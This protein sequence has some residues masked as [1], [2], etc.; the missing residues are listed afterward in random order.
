[1]VEEE[2]HFQQAI[3]LGV[4]LDDGE[5]AALLGERNNQ[6][7]DM[8]TYHEHL[9]VGSDQ[10]EQAAQFLGGVA[11]LRR[12]FSADHHVLDPNQQGAMITLHQQSRGFPPDDLSSQ[13][14]ELVEYEKLEWNQ[15]SHDRAGKTPGTFY[16]PLAV[17]L[18]RVADCMIPFATAMR[19]FEFA[20]RTDW[21]LTSNAYTRALEEHR[22][23]GKE[24]LD[25]T[26]SN[27]TN[28]G[29]RYDQE[30]LLQALA[31]PE[32][33]TYEPIPKGVLPAR[34]AIFG[35]YAERGVHLS[36]EDLV[37]TTSTSEA[38][39]FIFRLL[40]DP[41]DAVLVPTPSYPLFDFLADLQDVKL[42]PYELVYDHG[43]Q[44]DFHSLT[45]ALN[46]CSPSPSHPLRNNSAKDGAP[47]GEGRCKAVLVVH[48]NNPTGSFL[49]QQEA[50][51]LSRLC[52]EKNLAIVS[53]E[54][55]LDYSL[56]GGLAASS[57]ASGFDEHGG[58]QALTF[59]LSG[60]SKISGLPQMKVAWIAVAGPEI[61][62][63]EALSRLE[64]IADTYL[65][66]NA[67]LQWA[68]PEMLGERHNIQKQL[69]S[70]IRA[71][72]ENLDRQLAGQK[73]CS[74]L[75]V[76]GG[77]Y[78]ILRVPATKSDEELA[79]AILRQTGVL[80]QPGHFY[81]FARDGYLVLS[82]ITPQEIFAPGIERL[83][84]FL[85]EA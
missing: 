15:I 48:P 51:Q 78:V 33:L 20:R 44:M 57:F 59:A 11:A 37:L 6:R 56:G 82:L 79:I 54:V 32:A 31:K 65:S 49:K 10:I 83:L 27:P 38:Y 77:W 76:E 23:S 4:G 60:L 55:F 22:R 70:R 35:Y 14:G 36:P 43:W 8:A 19:A 74:R 17:G 46:R 72:L 12:Q 68:I 45:Q 30:K 2:I 40:C 1:M 66:M 16:R 53:D 29:L 39:S 67:P 28:I 5:R 69:M 42:V 84:R 13:L 18:V 63:K 75:E 26:A 21:D 34:E 7:A 81:D 80:V 3:V 71:N 47:A 50:V 41:G 62:K 61:L 25:L 58:S 85:A 73:L 24:V 64:V 52:A 9:R